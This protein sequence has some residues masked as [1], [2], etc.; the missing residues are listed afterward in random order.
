MTRTPPSSFREAANE[1]R[2]S[3]VSIWRRQAHR[4]RLRNFRKLAGAAATLNLAF[5][6]IFPGR[7]SGVWF[8]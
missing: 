6:N 3:S 8:P 1:C 2:L 4:R 7:S 5:F